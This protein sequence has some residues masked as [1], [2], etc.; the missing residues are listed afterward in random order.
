MYKKRTAVLLLIAVSL[1]SMMLAACGKNDTLESYIKNNQEAQ[2]AIDEVIASSAEQ[3]VVVEIKGN[4]I[5]YNCDIS[6]MEGITS[7]LAKS[8]QVKD[9]LK[10]GMDG[11]AENFKEVASYMSELSGIDDIKVVV[12]YTYENETILQNTYE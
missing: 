6:G 2:E 9:L 4:E 3:G 8:D 10:E 5:I 11:Q 7:E 12:K 1:F